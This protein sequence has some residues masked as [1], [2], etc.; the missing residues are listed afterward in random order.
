M[1][2]LPK[3]R[4][5]Y[6][7]TV[8][9]SATIAVILYTYIDLRAALSSLLGGLF[10]TLMFWFIEMIARGFLQKKSVAITG[11][12]IVFKYAI[13]G[14]ILYFALK[15]DSVHKVSFLIGFLSFVPGSIFWVLK[16]KKT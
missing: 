9:T 2:E 14:I 13:L 4:S 11:S 8:L 12:V 5:F 1:I 3:T 7:S 10:G 15:S 16:I 6:I